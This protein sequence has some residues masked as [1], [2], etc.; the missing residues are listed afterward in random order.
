MANLK[1]TD[2]NTTKSMGSYGH[3]KIDTDTYIFPKF[4]VVSCIEVKAGTATVTGK[5]NIEN[6]RD[7]LVYD[8]WVAEVLAVGTHIVNLKEVTIVASGSFVVA[9]YGGE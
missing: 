7:K 9:H 5:Q 1:S 6:K 8:S 2:V 4:V 3:K